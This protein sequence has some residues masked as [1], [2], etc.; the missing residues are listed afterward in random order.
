MFRLFECCALSFFERFVLSFSLKI[1][2][3]VSD[4]AEIWIC[5]LYKLSLIPSVGVYASYGFGAG[6]CSLDV[7]HQEGDNITTEPAKWKPLDGF[8]Y[9]AGEPNNSGNLQAFRRWDYGG[10]VGMKAVIADHYT[11]SFDYR[12]GI[13]K[14]QAQNGLRNSTFQ[15]SVGYRF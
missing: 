12:V 3:F 10:I 6:N 13:K 4:S 2:R 7:I 9:K 8:S 11:I 15:F 14:I 1:E 5:G